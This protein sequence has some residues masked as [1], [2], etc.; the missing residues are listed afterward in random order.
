MPLA[1]SVMCVRCQSPDEARPGW[2]SLVQGM[3]QRDAE[4]VVTFCHRAYPLHLI[5]GVKYLF[6]NN[7]NEKKHTKQTN[8]QK[9]LCCAEE[10]RNM[11]WMMV[12]HQPS[13]KI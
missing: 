1:L 2:S 9:K 13:S 7:N 11:I 3:E 6:L 12:K 8:K 4:T 5:L 10:A